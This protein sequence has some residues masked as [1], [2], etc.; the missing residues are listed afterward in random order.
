M[1]SL[2]RFLIDTRSLSFKI[3]FGAWFDTFVAHERLII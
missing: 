2:L 3:R 1:P